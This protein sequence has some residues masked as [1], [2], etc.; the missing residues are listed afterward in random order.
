MIDVSDARL[1]ARL[2]GRRRRELLTERDRRAFAGA[3]VL[4]TG[5][6][7]V[8]SC[9][10][11]EIAR[12][13]PDSLTVVEQSEHHLCAIERALD[14]LCPEVEVDAVLGD[15]SRRRTIELT[16]RRARPEVVFHS[17]ACSRVALCERAVCRAV[18]T[19][20]FGTLFTARAAADCGSRFIL[21][22]NDQAGRAHSVMGATRR[23][24][25]LVV[26]AR[27]SGLFRPVV[28][29]LGDVL[30]SRGGLLDVVADRI[31]RG[32]PLQIAEPAATRRFMTPRE[33]V[34]LVMK[35][36]LI[37]E[38]GMIYWLDAGRP[39]SVQVLVR[40]ALEIAVERGARPVPVEFTG[41]GTGERL[42]AEPTGHG[43]E[44]RHAGHPGISGARQPLFDG[45]VV[46]RVLHAL[47]E[48]VRRDD[49]G[50]AIMDLQAAV[51]DFEPTDA[52]WRHA[53][54]QSVGAISPRMT[55][56]SA[57]VA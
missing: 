5:A 53:F 22:S 34:G 29:R 23:L 39:M 48:D 1:H 3:R 15:V 32:L 43:L 30:G 2:L 17:A 56:H 55:R 8:G 21:V 35:V 19:N 7:S 50:S 57:S 37:G 44:P 26:L 31:R 4:V 27:F 41:L 40:R 51:P 16:F 9:L 49:A 11:L 47:R 25:E 42:R 18:R 10:A 36:A 28:V 12:C 14:E 20:V 45:H 52:T 13:R 54:A 24:A 46:R 33:A 38:G 6:G